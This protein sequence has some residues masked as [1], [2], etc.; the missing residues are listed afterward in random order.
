MS[1]YFKAPYELRRASELAEIRQGQRDLMDTHRYRLAGH[2]E[3]VR[4]AEPTGDE[5]DSGPD[6]IIT[7]QQRFS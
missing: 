1:A 6:N 5:D 7:M 4:E 3:T 2:I